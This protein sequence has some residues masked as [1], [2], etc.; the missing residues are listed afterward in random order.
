MDPTSSTG[1]A[2]SHRR[3]R[4]GLAAVAVVA[5][6]VMVA[7]NCTEVSAAT[8]PCSYGTPGRT[9]LVDHPPEGRPYEAGTES[10]PP[11]QRKYRALT[12]ANA[13]FSAGFCECVFPRPW[14]W[15][16]PLDAALSIMRA[17]DRKEQ[18]AI[19]AFARFG[20][21]ESRVPVEKRTIWLRSTWR[22]R[23]E[24]EC[25]Y[26]RVGPDWV[27]R[28]GTSRHESGY[29]ID[30]EDWGAEWGGTDIRLLREQGWCWT[31]NTEPW[32]WEHRPTLQRLGLGHRCIK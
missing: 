28:P 22:S 6:L 13:D 7:A 23:E 9:P 10:L 30:L 21:P 32:H 15:G 14:A 31:V 19:A 24:Q 16:M 8:Y 27:A 1:T 25:L 4:G 5:A 18:E 12:T 26:T 3:R 20:V 2:L 11:S 29:A 17:M